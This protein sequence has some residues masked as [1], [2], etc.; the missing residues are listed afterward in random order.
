MPL[1]LGASMKRNMENDIEWTTTVVYAV[2]G[3]VEASLST[4]DIFD[5]NRKR[6]RGDNLGFCLPG[7][8]KER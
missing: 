4:I 3:Q 5:R 1:K 8:K 6:L 7:P 2:G